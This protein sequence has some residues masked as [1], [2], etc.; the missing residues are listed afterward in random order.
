ML[1]PTCFVGSNYLHNNVIRQNLNIKLTMPDDRL[2]NCSI[3]NTD[4]P[5]SDKVFWIT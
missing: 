2:G 4:L 3:Q 1:V 5:N